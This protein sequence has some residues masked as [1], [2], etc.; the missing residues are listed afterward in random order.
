MTLQEALLTAIELFLGRL[1]LYSYA[2]LN[3]KP[4]FSQHFSPRSFQ[5]ALKAWK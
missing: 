5:L 3:G 4:K 2:A 1:A